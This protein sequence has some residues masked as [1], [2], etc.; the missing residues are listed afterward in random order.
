MIILN[1][2]HLGASS[3]SEGPNIRQRF[4]PAGRKQEAITNLEQVKKFV[5]Y[6]GQRC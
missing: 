3:Y 5:I 6:N 1:K 4:R 2:T